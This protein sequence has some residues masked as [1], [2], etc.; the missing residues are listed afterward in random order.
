M[1]MQRGSTVQDSWAQNKV[2]GVDQVGGLIGEMRGDARLLGTN[3]AVTDVSG[4]L[5][6]GGLVGRI[7]E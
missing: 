6:V 5:D 1:G 4:E 3:Y 2:T 7:L